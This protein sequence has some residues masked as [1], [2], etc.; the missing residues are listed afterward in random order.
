MG[1]YDIVFLLRILLGANVYLGKEK[2]S[3]SIM[4]R[5]DIIICLTIQVGSHKVKLVDSYNYQL[6]T[7][8][9]DLGQTF[10]SHV[11]KNIYLSLQFCL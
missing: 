7:S 6:S 11:K 1:R 4:S 10:D 8:L 3:R 2:Y 5:E 9:Y